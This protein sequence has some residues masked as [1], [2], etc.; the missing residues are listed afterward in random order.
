MTPPWVAVEPLAAH[1]DIDEFRSGRESV[2]TWFPEKALSATHVAA[3]KMPGHRRYRLWLLCTA[4][5]GRE[6]VSPA[7]EARANERQGLR[8]RE[9]RGE[10][11]QDPPDDEQPGLARR[12]AQQRGEGE[13]DEADE[14]SSLPPVQIAETTA[15]GERHC[16]C[17]SVTG[18]DLLAQ[19]V[20]AAEVVLDR[21][22]G[23]IDDEEIQRRQQRAGQQRDHAHPFAGRRI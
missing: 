13:P 3:T 6:R 21:R 18:Y 20:A 15:E 1:H 5:R 12:T 11:L 9:R 8:R 7:I 10:T 19:D 16:V 17:G 23:E 14:K 4:V 22:D 2:D